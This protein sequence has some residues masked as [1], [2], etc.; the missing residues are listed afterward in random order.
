MQRKPFTPPYKARRKSAECLANF[1]ASVLRA[2]DERARRLAIGGEL[3]LD[4]PMRP[5][6]AGGYPIKDLVQLRDDE[7]PID[8]LYRR[9]R[10]AR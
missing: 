5:R 1:R 8:A 7:V 6:P 3:K 9:Q 4:G 10:G 2:L